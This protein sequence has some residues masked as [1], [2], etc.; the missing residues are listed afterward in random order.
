MNVADYL[1]YRTCDPADCLEIVAAMSLADSGPEKRIFF[2]K[3]KDKINGFSTC[4]YDHAHLS[5]C[6]G[7]PNRRILVKL[8]MVR[9]A[10]I[11]EIIY[12]FNKIHKKIGDLNLLTPDGL[13]GYDVRL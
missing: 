5:W 7:F 2:K 9:W 1:L 8:H 10:S 6:C 13:V 4:V 11:E 12:F 3:K